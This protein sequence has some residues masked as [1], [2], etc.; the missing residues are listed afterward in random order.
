MF[1]DICRETREVFMVAVP[2]RSAPTLLN[3]INDKIEPGSV[4]MS[5]CWRG[6]SGLKN[7]DMYRHLTVNHRLNFVDPESGIF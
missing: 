3:V 6:Y 4:V 5:D 2:D 7:N 1:G